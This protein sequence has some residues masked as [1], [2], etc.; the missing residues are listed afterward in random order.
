MPQISTDTSRNYVGFGMRMLASIIDSILSIII[1]IPFI[2]I[3]QK[4]SGVDNISVMLATGE[5]TFETMSRQQLIDLLARQFISLTYQ[6]ILMAVAILSFWVCRSATPGKMMLKMI[7][8]DEK[9]GLKP[10]TKQLIIRYLGYFV[11][12]L[13]LA[14]GFVWIHYDKKKQ[15]WHDKLAGTSVIYKGN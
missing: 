5:L 11:A 7:I 2:T 6:N 10:S 3:F 15:G 14:M 12:L 8:I 13:P 1:L 9:T 4:I